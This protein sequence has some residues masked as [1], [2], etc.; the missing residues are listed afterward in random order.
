MATSVVSRQHVRPPSVRCRWP[1]AFSSEKLANQLRAPQQQERRPSLV[2]TLEPQSMLHRLATPAAALLLLCSLPLNAQAPRIDKIDP[3]NWWI[4]MPAP[5]FLLKR[6]YLSGA[7]FTSG[8][9]PIERTVVS[10]NGHWAELWLT[11]DATAASEIALKAET[12]QGKAQV[13]F[14]F[15]A[16]RTTST[17]F[18][19]FSSRDVM[20][21][22]MTDRFAD[23]DQANDGPDAKDSADSAAAKA[24]RD[25]P[26]G[27]HGGDLR[28]IIDH[29]DYLQTLGITTIWITP[30]YQNHSPEAYHGYSA[31]DMYAVGQALHE[32]GMKLVLDTVPN[33][34]G[35]RHPWVDD[36]PEPNWFHGTKAN[37]SAAVMEFQPLTD[38]YAPWRDKRDITEGWFVD[39]L[40]DNNQ[41]NPAVAK[42]LIQNAI[43]WT[44]ETSL[45]GLRI[46]TFPYVGREFWNQFHSQLQALYPS[47]T[48]VGEISNPDPQ[49][50]SSFAGGVTRNG[51]DTGLWSPLDYPLHYAIR[52]AFTGSTSMQDLT[53]VLRQ[54]ALYPHPERLTPF[55]DNHDVI[56]FASEPGGSLEANK[57]AMAFLLTVR[58]M[59]QLY[60]G[61]EIYM[62][63]Y[64]DPDNRHDFPGGFSNTK[65]NGFQSST[66]TAAQTEMY[67]WTSNLLALRK[68]TPALLTGNMQILYTSYDSIVYL[69][70]EGSQRILIAIHRGK[71]GT[72]LHVSTAQTDLAGLATSSHLFGEGTV[73][74]EAD[75]VAIELPPNGVLISSIR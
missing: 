68:R 24:E 7:P 8:E 17:G 74:A 71:E 51:V 23:G 35:P 10:E 56:R 2:T 18:A 48:T 47:L 50:V 70:T 27:W 38:P 40:P 31:T 20:Y 53:A 60:S 75:G 6:E 14:K 32:R 59:P 65:N 52:N 22:I 34:V 33:H 9:L 11:K 55:I 67:E 57:L 43:W 61:D 28:G 62:E 44:E 21:L 39:V 72:V 30:V 16:R 45:D 26:R 46:D 42:Y 49:I 58:G 69:R 37:H 36:S 25:K 64:Q 4:N 66:R 73:R 1:F 3:P 29:L 63:G 5:I 19:G 54:D 15:E 12:R 41:G 13:P